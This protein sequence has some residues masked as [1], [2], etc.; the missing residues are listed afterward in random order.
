[1]IIIPVK[2]PS[3]SDH[4]F[5]IRD[6]TTSYRTAVSTKSKKINQSLSNEKLDICT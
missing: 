5:R 6:S 1:M 2:V 4:F 3:D